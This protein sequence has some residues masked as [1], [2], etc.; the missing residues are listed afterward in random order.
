MTPIHLSTFLPF[1]NLISGLNMILR[2]PLSPNMRKGG[3]GV[4]ETHIVSK[5]LIYV[6]GKTRSM[7]FQGEMVITI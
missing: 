6:F 1:Q 4:V 7:S 5:G 2:G 3:E